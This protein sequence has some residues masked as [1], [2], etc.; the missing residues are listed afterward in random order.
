M[1]LLYILPLLAAFMLPSCSTSSSKIRNLDQMEASEYEDLKHQV[2]TITALASS[3]AARGWDAEKRDK[4]L[5]IIAEGRQLIADGGLGDLN[6]TDLIRALADRY[7]EK[8][9][10]DEDAKRD[11]KDAALLIDIVAGPIKLGIDGSLDEREEGLILA[12]LDGLELGIK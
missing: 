6:A 3:R 8:L 9:G 2:S 1:K 4:A 7:S 5:G 12:L 10:L 11:I